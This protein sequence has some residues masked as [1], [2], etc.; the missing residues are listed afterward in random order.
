ME[1]AGVSAA[2]AAPVAIERLSHDGR[3]I[4]HR[5]GKTVFVS[6]ALP[7]E[8]VRLARVRTRRRFDEAA[9]AEILECA[10]ERTAPP[11]PHF[12]TCGGCSLQHMSAAAQLAAK[13]DSLLANLERVGGLRPEAV[14]APIPGPAYGYRRRA[15]LAVRDVP[16]KGRVLVGF[17]EAGGRFVTDAEVCPI[18]VPP[19]AQLPGPLARL[20]ETLDLRTRVPQVE[21]AAGDG[22][23]ALVFRVL[24]EPSSADRSRLQAFGAEHG[25]GIWLQRGGSDS[26]QR[27]CGPPELDYAL[28]EFGLELSFL[29]TDFVQVNAAVNRALVGAA[30]ARLAPEGERV[31]E[32]FAGIG[33]FSLALARSAAEVVSVE[34]SAELVA[35]ARANAAANG[36][37]N[38]AAHCADLAA[39]P[40]RPPWLAGRFGAVLLDPPR[41]GA[42]ELVARLARL[43]PHRVLYVSCHPATLARD[44]AAFAGHGFRLLAAGIADMFPHTAH[45]EAMALFGRD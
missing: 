31:L 30:V 22:A 10:P 8:T 33:N 38:L 18:L 32:L 26:A 6:G 13:Q 12:G 17:H 40:V 44:G 36:V 45:A 42:R 34:G 39:A 27:L 28:P 11:C 25:L 23:A 5:A 37:A 1:S 9:A 20:I 7:G 29:P 35:R 21:F 41:S 19:G 24:D 4:A 3:G 2:A 16:A 14:W 43:A 15:R